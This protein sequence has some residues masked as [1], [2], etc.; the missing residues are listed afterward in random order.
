MFSVNVFL[1]KACSVIGRI[2]GVQASKC[3][4]EDSTYDRK[5]TS[6]NKF[7]VLLI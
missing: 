7:P 1:H 2:D 3:K 5:W 6:K 4:S